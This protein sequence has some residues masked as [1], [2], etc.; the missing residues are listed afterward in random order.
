MFVLMGLTALILRG[1]RIARYW[2]LL[3]VLPFVIHFVTPGA[4]GGIRNSLFP[5]EGLAY[6]ALRTRRSAGVRTP[7]RRRPGP[8]PLGAVA[9][10]RARPRQPRRDGLGPGASSRRP[11]GADRS[12]VGVD[13]I[14]DNQYLHTLVELGILGLVGTI[15]FV[16]G[17]G[18]KLAGTSRRLVDRRGDLI[19]ACATSCIGFGGALLALRRVRVRPGDARVL[20]RR[21]ARAAGARAG[22]GAGAGLRLV[23]GPATL[24]ASAMGSKTMRLTVSCSRSARC[25]P[26]GFAMA[27]V[28]SVTLTGAGPQPKALT[29]NWGDTVAFTNGDSQSQAI[30]HPPADGRQ[31]RDPSGRN[32]LPGVRGPRRQLHLPPG[33]LAQ[34]PG[35]DRRRGQRHRDADGQA[36]LRA[37]R[38][39]GRV[40]GAIRVPGRPVVVEQ[41]PLGTTTWAEAAQLVAGA[42]GAFSTSLAPTIGARYRATAAAGQLRSGPIAV[43]VRPRLTLSVVPRRGAAGRRGARSRRG[44]LRPRPCGASTSSATS[45]D[46]GGGCARAR[47]RSAERGR[48][49]PLGDP[50]GGL[51]PARRCASR[52]APP[53]LRPG[54]ERAGRRHR[55]G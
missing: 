48:D 50:A 5:E 16:W 54:D 41:L 34:L 42:D 22:C 8:A 18:L 31:P 55:R 27:A 45:R 21:R 6:R 35:H 10:V 40:P 1:R 43:G 7:R 36:G 2:P 47:A 19:A 15:W 33:R 17:A 11:A 49:L 39:A 14:F 53:G 3:I 20:H 29:V 28:S 52:G 24:G 38:A 44:R 51:A 23:R 4:L 30:T 12:P 37:V 9:A 25:A 32:V 26:A 13:I 46:G